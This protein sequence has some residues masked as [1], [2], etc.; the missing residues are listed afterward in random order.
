MIYYIESWDS[1]LHESAT[2]TAAEIPNLPSGWNSDYRRCVDSASQ[3]EQH[4]QENYR[5]PETDGAKSAVQV[6]TAR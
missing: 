2:R 1:P 5:G 3:I 6:G 4:S